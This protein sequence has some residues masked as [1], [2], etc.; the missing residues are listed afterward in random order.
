MTTFDPYGTT[1]L[2]T[3]RRIWRQDYVL[4][5]TPDG[6]AIPMGETQDAADPTPPCP[7]CKRVVRDPWNHLPEMCEHHEPHPASIAG[8][9]LAEDDRAEAARA[10]GGAR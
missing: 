2:D 10:I 3:R 1:D 7:T 9:Q 5:H 8:I 4:T 6:H